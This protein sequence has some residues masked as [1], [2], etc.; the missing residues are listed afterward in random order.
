MADK[1][2]NLKQSLTMAD[3]SNAVVRAF[4]D[5]TIIGGIYFFL[6]GILHFHHN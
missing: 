5:I 3:F 6:C 1:A 2:L 4:I